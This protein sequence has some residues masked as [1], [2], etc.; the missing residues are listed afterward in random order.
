MW[1]IEGLQWVWPIHA[2]AILEDMLYL[3]TLMA[4]AT[5]GVGVLLPGYVESLTDLS[6]KE[7]YREK[8]L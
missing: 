7:K 3:D 8:F 1:P 4:T 5:G 2:V 6:S